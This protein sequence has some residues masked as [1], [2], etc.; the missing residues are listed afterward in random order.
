MD[1]NIRKR[2]GQHFLKNQSAIGKIIAAVNPRPG[3]TI[4]EIGPGTGALTV[5][6]A[7]ACEARGCNI[8]AIEKDERLA[9]EVKNKIEEIRLTAVAEIVSA[10]ILKILAS[11]VLPLKSPYKLIGNLPYY[12]TGKLLRTVSELEPKPAACVFTLQREVAERIVAE[13]PTMNLLA[14]AVQI[15]AEP[16]IV[17]CLK[18]SDF[19]P[20]PKVESAI[21]ALVT[22]D[23]GQ[24]TRNELANYYRFI[25][26]IFKQPRKTVL[27]NLAAGFPNL[28][29][30]AILTILQENSVSASARPQNLSLEVLITL[31]RCV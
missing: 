13:P 30:R 28:A 27:N 14:A 3:E 21:I 2:L 25:K 4:I 23:M 8:I 29:R 5:P 17:A 7:R 22:R 18:P 6:L 20:P 9:R 12:I 10:D 19:S 24:A 16:T 31:S 1:T 11:Y 26:I 15:W